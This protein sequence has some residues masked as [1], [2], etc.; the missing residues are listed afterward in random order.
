[1]SPHLYVFVSNV[2]NTP[3]FYYNMAAVTWQ[4]ALDI[5]V[6]KINGW[7]SHLMEMLPNIILALIVLVVSF[8]IGRI[9]RRLVIK[10]GR[11]V[12]NKALNRLLSTFIFILVLLGGLIVAL[13]VLQL[14]KTVTS[15][16]AGVGI[17][18]LALGFAFQ[19]IAAN[20]MSGMI[21][22]LQRPFKNGD[23]VGIQEYFGRI[24]NISLRTTEMTTLDGLNV[25]IPNKMMVENA[26]INYTATKERRVDLEVGV[27]YGDDLVKVEKVTKKALRTVKGSDKKRPAEVFFKEFGDSSINLLARFWITESEQIPYLAARSDAVIAIKHAYDKAGITI[28]W[29]IRTLSF[30]VKGGQGLQDV[31]K[32]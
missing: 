23:L 6:G 8:L 17:I 21:I 10:A 7:F 30:D 14:E 11:H 3:C 19:D 5:L 24:N 22:A 1:M 13:A 28:P 12:K 32:K 9:V 4:D 16:L 15:L 20:F 26:M 31:L 2:K 27:S 29:P 25:I 18:G